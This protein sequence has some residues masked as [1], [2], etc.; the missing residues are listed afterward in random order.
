MDTTFIVSFL[1]SPHLYFDGMPISRSKTLML[2]D[3]SHEFLRVLID[4]L[5]E[6]LKDIPRCKE[7]KI[8]EASEMSSTTCRSNPK[9]TT[10]GEGTWLIVHQ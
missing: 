9:Q 4:Q 7:N 5:C 8:R 6:D 3:D 2:A 10:G 1:S